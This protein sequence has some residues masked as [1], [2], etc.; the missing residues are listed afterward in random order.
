[1]A[2]DLVSSWYSG[3]GN[4]A[5]DAEGMAYWNSQLASGKSAA[6]VQQDFMNSAK[7]VQIPQGLLGTLQSGNI[8]NNLT[9]HVAA[10]ATNQIQWQTINGVPTM[11]T[12]EMSQW[13]GPNPGP[14]MT[15]EQLKAEG[16]SVVAD[17]QAKGLLPSNPYDPNNPY[18]GGSHTANGVQLIPGAPGYNAAAAAPWLAQINQSNDLINSYQRSA[19]GFGETGR[20]GGQDGRGRKGRN[21]NRNDPIQGTAPVPVPTQTYGTPFHISQSSPFLDRSRTGG[22]FNY[23]AS[24]FNNGGYDS[25]RPFGGGL[26]PLV[27]QTVGAPNTMQDTI[28]ALSQVY[29]AK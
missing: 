10:P 12:P 5:P 11:I 9:G 17:Q 4:A 21:E 19:G 24:P 13:Q 3:I 18:G 1:M 2:N 25:L 6:Q 27:N 7:S 20:G 23:G 28:G 26:P 14:A 8:V 29:N 16:D 15:W 22:W